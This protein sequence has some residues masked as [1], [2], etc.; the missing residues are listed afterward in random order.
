MNR[1][2]FISILRT[3]V[4]DLQPVGSGAAREWFV[5]HLLHRHK[6]MSWQ[7]TMSRWSCR[8]GA[9][10]HRRFRRRVSRKNR[11][12]EDRSGRAW[13][14]GCNSPGAHRAGQSSSTGSQKSRDHRTARS[15]D[16]TEAA[17][18]AVRTPKRFVRF[19]L[20]NSCPVRGAEARIGKRN[21]VRPAGSWE[22]GVMRSLIRVWLSGHTGGF[23]Q[24]WLAHDCPR[25]T[26]SKMRGRGGSVRCATV[27]GGRRFVG[28]GFHA[29][30]LPQI[31]AAT[32]R[33][34]P[35]HRLPF[36]RLPSMRRPFP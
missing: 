33:R 19:T 12:V 30:S 17:L 10:R 25:A 34:P 16:E 13:C 5:D 3:D 23:A 20:R 6:F 7:R 29:F 9:A 27:S 14:R 35:R 11:S 32:K 8:A 4:A 1:K 21:S 28:A 22:R 31:E 15:I 18:R 2:I 36:P 24:T 26:W